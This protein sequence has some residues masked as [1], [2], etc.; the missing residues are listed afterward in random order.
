MAGIH[1]CS[2]ERLLVVAGGLRSVT[3]PERADAGCGVGVLDTEALRARSGWRGVFCCGITGIETLGIYSLTHGLR[4]PSDALHCTPITKLPSTPKLPSPSA[5]SHHPVSL[6]ASFRFLT[7]R[8][9]MV[10]K[11]FL[12]ALG[13]RDTSA[14]ALCS[15]KG[16][17]SILMAWR[18]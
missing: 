2:T 15:S 6:A 14:R 1:T 16:K 9:I 5:G 18:M 11:S 10:S 4:T 17:R 12:S 3:C 7:R 13:A 8:A